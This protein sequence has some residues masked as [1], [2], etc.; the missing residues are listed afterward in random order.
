M[1]APPQPDMELLPTFVKSAQYIMGLS[2]RQ[3]VW[4]HLGRLV[5]THFHARW[6]AF[7]QC[8]PAGELSLDHCV[9]PTAVA[10]ERLLSAETRA[11]VKEVLDSGFLTCQVLASPFESPSMTVFLPITGD[12]QPNRVMLVGHDTADPLP[13]QRLDIYLALAGLAGTMLERLHVENELEAHHAHLEDLVKARTAELA[14]AKRQNELILNSLGEGVLGVGLAGRI[15]FANPAAGDLTGWR[16]QELIDRDAHS[17]FHQKTCGGSSG[18][19]ETCAVH[20]TL[21]DGQ[22]RLV[23]DEVFFRKDGT[24]FP[25]EFKTT[26]IME[27]DRIAGVVLVF[28]DITEQRRAQAERD[29]AEQELRRTA[30]NLARSNKDLEQFAYVCSHDLQE[31]LRQVTGFMNLL[32][33][34]YK[35]KLDKQADGFIRY[36]VDGASRMSKLIRDLLAYS[37]VDASDKQPG[38]ISCQEALDGALANLGAAIAE[39]GARVTHDALPS[40]VADSGQIVQLFQNLIGNALKFRREGVT[41]QIHVGAR[42]DGDKW[43]LS[44]K[45][46]GIGISA[47][48]FDRVFAIFQRLHGREKYPGTGIGLAICKKIVERHGGR[49]W[50]ESTVGESTTFYFA[51]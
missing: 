13:N 38:V 21:R 44:V 27:D 47:E 3:D 6:T 32:E 42:Q 10:A 22:P 4:D 24:V 36:A 49:I 50:V 9:L 51:L 18:E 7:V 20:A 31:P 37:R 25:V 8:G 46:N 12:H 41:P 40:V 26:A 1:S 16:P 43:V 45:D 33:E 39:S 5:V 35:G 2:T 11:L 17:T 28:R 14:N 34:R 19:T 29:R 48:Q 23:A 15:S 30:E